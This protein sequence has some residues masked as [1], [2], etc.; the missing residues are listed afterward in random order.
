MKIPHSQIKLF[1]F[2]FVLLINSVSLCFANEF[3]TKIDSSKT[4]TISFK[5]KL[6]SDN[7]VKIK[8]APLKFNKHFAYSFTLDDGYRSAYL[9][10]FPLL[11]GGKI[12]SPDKNEWKIDQGGDGTTSKG[13]F[14]SDGFGNKIPFKLALA[15]NG[16]VIRDLP[17]NRGHLSWPEIKEMYNAGWDILN[18]GFHHATKHGTNYLTEVTENT[19]S[20]KQ[21]LDFTMSH[22]VV[23]GGEGDEKYYLEYEK[24]AL[25]NGYFSVASYYGV[26]P[27]FNVDS[28][29]NLDKMITVRTF[30]QS[31]KD[32]TSFKTMDRYLKTMDSIV[33]Q[34]N[35]IWFNEFTHGTGNTNL[36]SLSMR[37]HDFKYYITTLANKYG[38]KG[39]DSIWMAPWQEVYEYIWL[40]DRIKVDYKQK[41]K[42]IE[43]TIELPEIPENFRYHDISLAVDT[44]S[45]FE[46][47][48]NKG[49]KIKNDGKTTHKQI[50]IQQK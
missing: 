17:A 48:S 26:G 30:V 45:K 32:T 11:N 10:A 42:E 8:P 41:N 40:R 47:E 4:K 33:K 6:K 2:I 9:T 21:N 46:I 12:S 20:I 27:V 38:A 1:L 25:N 50:L 44:S 34:P 14:Y 13:L 49:L 16:G 3:N 23:P 43:V 37:F 36:W 24:E 22:F 7:K 29:V 19:T 5:I 15:V 35:T 28:K 39:K 31:S 18:H